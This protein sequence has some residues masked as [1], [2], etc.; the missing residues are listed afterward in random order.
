[1]GNDGLHGAMVLQSNGALVVTQDEASCVVFGMPKAVADA[2]LSH[3]S[4][5]PPE[6]A[7]LL[8]KL[9]YLHAEKPQ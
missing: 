6:I 5:T 9:H 2:G 8:L 7:A 4:L 1:M 3:C